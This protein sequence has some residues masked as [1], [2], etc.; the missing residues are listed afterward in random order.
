MIRRRATLKEIEDSYLWVQEELGGFDWD[1]ADY[2][3]SLESKG[4]RICESPLGLK[5]QFKVLFPNKRVV[6]LGELEKYFKKTKL[7]FGNREHIFLMEALKYLG[8]YKKYL[9]SSATASWFWR[10]HCF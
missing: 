4:F 3:L 7:E 2:L 10:E 5:S 9:K 1:D 6:S 8:D